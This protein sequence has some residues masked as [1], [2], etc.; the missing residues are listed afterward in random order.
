MIRHS[1]LGAREKPCRQ[2][3]A[4][5]PVSGAVLRVAEKL[6]RLVGENEPRADREAEALGRDL[7][8]LEK[9]E[10]AHDAGDRIAVG[11]PNADMLER[12][13]LRDE[14]LRVRRAAQKGEIRRRRKLG[15][16]G[17]GGDHGALRR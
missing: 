6:G 5:A 8:D 17:K 16:A 7:V 10:G 12:Q 1:P 2:Q 11:D 15:V 9:G 3:P 14:F 13:R 4:E